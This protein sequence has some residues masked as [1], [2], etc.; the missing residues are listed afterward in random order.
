MKIIILSIFLFH[1]NIYGID[2]SLYE[3]SPIIGATK[4]GDINKVQEYIN[5]GV[6]IN[7]ANYWSETALTFALKENFMNIVELLLAN[8]AE[9]HKNDLLYVNN[10]QKLAQLL[11]DH[12]A[13][14]KAINIGFNGAVQSNRLEMVKFFLD[15]GAEINE[16]VWP[17]SVTALGLAIRAKNTKMENLLLSNGASLFMSG[18][19]LYNNDLES[20]EK[21]L[22]AGM[23]PNCTPYS[24][25]DPL[26]L[27]AYDGNYSL[28]KLLIK[29]GADINTQKSQ[30]E[31][32]YGNTP[33]VHAALKNNLKLA[34]LLLQNGANPNVS[35]TSVDILHMLAKRNNSEMIELLLEYGAELEKTTYS[36]K[37]TPLMVAVKNRRKDAIKV[38]LKYKANILAI[39]A[40]GESPLSWA[41]ENN[42]E[43]YQLLQNK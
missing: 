35:G 7:E 22:K 34:K 17:H 43:I 2:S 32:D 3:D 39:N 5:Q 24:S 41:K 16:K 8:G 42:Q 31:G 6:D 28:A 4:A 30:P 25:Q 10:S 19:L 9:V 33:L 1:L 13:N 29:Y 26:I 11:I 21:L 37:D 15:K 40:K 38:F 12:G 14:Q 27:A 18:A 36:E 20:V 23:N